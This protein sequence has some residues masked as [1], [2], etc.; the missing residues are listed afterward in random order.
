MV[1]VLYDIT[2]GGP[3][4]LRELRAEI[5]ELVNDPGGW[6]DSKYDRL[7]KLDSVLRESQR[8]TP[9][10]V[11]GMKRLF[12]EPYIFSNGIHITKGTYVCMPTFVI[13]ND[14]A[15]TSEP[16]TFDGL[17]TYRKFLRLQVDSS[18]K[19]YLK[20]LSFSST[21]RT[22]LGFGFGK[23]ACPGRFFASLV[24]K[25][26]YVRLLT[27][28][29]FKFIPGDKRPTNIT[30]YEFMFCSP[31]QKMLIKRIQQ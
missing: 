12:R 19:R 2:A 11:L 8:M 30:A 14:P 25:M 26:L 13:E 16:T 17:R 1:N 24:L 21:G 10:T 15:H 31:A 3:E 28:Y 5:Q 27:Q 9:S 18:D 6:T 29:D 22:T 7:H 4:L 20:E 23:A